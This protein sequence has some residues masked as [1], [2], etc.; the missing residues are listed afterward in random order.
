MSYSKILAIDSH[1][2]TGHYLSGE[3][4]LLG[5]KPDEAKQEFQRAIEAER[6]PMFLD[7]LGR[8]A[9]I[10]STQ[11][12]GDKSL[13]DVALRSYQE[14]HEADPTMFNPLVSRGRIYVVRR[15]H[16][17]AV[18][19]LAAANA[20]KAGDPEVSYLLGVS[21][22]ELGQSALAIDWLKAANKT[23]PQAEANWRLGVLY[24]KTS[25]YQQ[26]A[27]ALA[28]ATRIATEQEKKDGKTVP[29]LTDALFLE[30]RVNAD[31]LHNEVGAKRAW[32]QYVVRNPAP[33]AQL[34]EVKR[35]LATDLK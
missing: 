31:G 18:P 26:A 6:Q 19:E 28:A 11:Q 9:E 34:D 7:A 13:Q 8:A 33:G 21:Y 30:G 29:W 14:A 35:R 22:M 17:K 24:E 3:G 2:A 10:L 12:N 1:N 16:A 27:A 25:Q 20:I 15:E 23:S 32:E 5:N 4:L